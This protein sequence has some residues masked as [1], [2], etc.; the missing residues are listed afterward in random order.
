MAEILHQLRLVV[1]PIIYRVLYIPG[2]ASF[3]PSTVSQNT[4]VREFFDVF[5]HSGR[6]D[7]MGHTDLLNPPTEPVNDWAVCQVVGAE[8]LLVLEFEELLLINLYDLVKL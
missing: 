2:G 5:F 1:Y 8:M 4:F 7:E 3:Q 6:K